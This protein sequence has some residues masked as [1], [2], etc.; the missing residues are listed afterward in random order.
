MDISY[1][2]KARRYAFEAHFRLFS[3]RSLLMTRRGS[4][5]HRSS[6]LRKRSHISRRFQSWPMARILDFIALSRFVIDFDAWFN[7]L[8]K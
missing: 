8:E 4:S 1:T 2:A 6:S 5:R 7:H 3:Y